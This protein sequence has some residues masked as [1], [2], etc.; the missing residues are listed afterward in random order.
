LGPPDQ[1]TADAGKN[2]TSQEFHQNASIIG[3]K[4]KIVP[5]EAHNSIG[6][7]ERYYA[8]VRRAYSIINTEI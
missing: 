5:V 2:F 7:V 8:V 6:K 4:V 3:I 1:I